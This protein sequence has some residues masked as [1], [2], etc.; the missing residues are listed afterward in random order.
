MIHDAVAQRETC[1]HQRFRYLFCSIRLKGHPG[2]QWAGR[3]EGP[4]IRQDETGETV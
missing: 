1:L 3:F 2:P 4:T